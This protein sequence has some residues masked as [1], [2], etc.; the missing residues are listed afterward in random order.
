MNVNVHWQETKK[1]VEVH[2]KRF[3]ALE[4]FKLDT[5]ADT[6]VRDEE[7]LLSQFSDDFSYVINQAQVLILVL[8]QMIIVHLQTNLYLTLTDNELNLRSIEI[9][10]YLV[11]D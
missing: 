5:S 11:T 10:D 1:S 3:E 7:L 4:K 6:V 8:T 9:M 2:N